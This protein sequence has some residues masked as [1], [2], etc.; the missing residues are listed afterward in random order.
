MIVNDIGIRT[1]PIDDD[2][3]DDDVLQPPKINGEF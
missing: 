1:R 2:V 3:D